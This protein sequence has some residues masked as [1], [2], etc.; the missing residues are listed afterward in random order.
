MLYT[1]DPNV[2][3]DWPQ[4]TETD[5][6]PQFLKRVFGAAA[7]GLDLVADLT[8]RLYQDKADTVTN[9]SLQS[10]ALPE[11]QLRPQ[12]RQALA[13]HER[14][15]TEPDELGEDWWADF[16]QE[17]QQNRLSLREV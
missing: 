15:F 12:N 9:Y 14:W 17:L 7:S 2:L 10:A 16:E 11:P 8:L 4:E 1:F 5:S 6:G 13:L 3:S